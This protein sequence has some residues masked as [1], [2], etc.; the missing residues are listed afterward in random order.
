[1]AQQLCCK[2]AQVR[3]HFRDI[4]NDSE[5]SLATGQWRANGA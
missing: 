4:R 3:Q 2:P 5:M 1:L